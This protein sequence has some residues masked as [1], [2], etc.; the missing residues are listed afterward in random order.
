MKILVLGANGMLGHVVTRHFLDIGYE[1]LET[2]R[3]KG[4][5]NYFDVSKD[6]SAI[7][8]VL[9][10]IKP[11]V[12]IN[13]IGIL[14]KNAEE[15]H[16]LAVMVNSYLPHYLDKISD[17]FDFKLIHIS[18]DCVF[19]GKKGEYCENSQKDSTSFYGQS[20]AL[21]EVK[22]DKNLTLRTSI[23][24]PDTNPNGIGLFQWF[25]NQETQTNGFNKVIWTGV[26]TIELAKCI[27]K[28]IKNNLVGLKHVVNGDT[29]DKLSL[30]KL[31]KKHFKKDIKIIPK[32]DYVVNKSLK[33]SDEFDFDIPTYDQMIKDMAEWVGRRKSLY[34][35]NQ[36][37]AK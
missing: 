10:R 17:E 19:D 32:S 37:G 2:S 9:K 29:I 30:L 22:N 36:G 12:V 23:I 11:K 3:D 27:D 1:V 4:D 33:K 18:T 16:D 24:G 20:K 14:N 6:I 8:K 21:G 31:I 34:S 35:K 26:T 5:I 28:A 15:N 7:Q 25:M 13:C